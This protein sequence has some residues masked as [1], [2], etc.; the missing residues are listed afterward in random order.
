M[1]GS[2][3]IDIRQYIEAFATEDG[4]YYVRCGHTGDR[5]VLATGNR[6]PDRATAHAAA[7]ATEQ[8][9]SAL[10]QY[11]PQVPYYDLIV[12]QTPRDITLEHSRGSR[13]E[14]E[15]RLSE[16]VIT[17]STTSERRDIVE[18]CHRVAGAV[19]ETLS[20]A[21]YDRVETAVMDAYL[22]LAETVGDPDE[23]CLCLLESMASELD[24]RLS[25]TDQSEV[26]ADAADRLESPPSDDT[27]FDTMLAALEER[28]VIESYTRSPYSV[29]LD[30]GVGSVVV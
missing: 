23:L 6:F 7:R 27:P 29:E 12:C 2:T 15:H 20:E 18:F 4:Q 8:Y 19:F 14:A 25:L 11:D 1:V 17:D 16:L 9:H 10:R 30:G 22:K 26:L 5:P 21:S 3:L 13:T 28:G 24:E